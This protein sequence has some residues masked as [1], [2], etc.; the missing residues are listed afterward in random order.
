MKEWFYGVVRGKITDN[1]GMDKKVRH[2]FVVDAT[3]F[4]EAE[5]VLVAEK[6]P[7]YK[8]PR[9]ISLKRESI[10]AVY[11]EC[12]TEN[13]VWWKVVIGL[14]W[15]DNKGR[16]KI[17]KYNYMVS[18]ETAGE[19]KDI[20]NKRMNGSVKDWKILKIE[21]TNVMEIISHKE[22]ETDESR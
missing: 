5:N 17:T 14:E 6:F 9:L 1:W 4:T 19:V 10:E 18:A 12:D 15:L 3:G 21:A 13:S 8:E 2:L 22:R 16:T 7:V 20:M 11:N